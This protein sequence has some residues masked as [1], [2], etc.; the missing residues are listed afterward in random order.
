MALVG[1]A[2][3]F[4]VAVTLLPQQSS[5]QQDSPQESACRTAANAHRIA[6]GEHMEIVVWKNR[7]MSEV[8]RVQADGTISSSNMSLKSVQA[9]GLSGPELL[10][11]LTEKLKDRFTVIDISVNWPRSRIWAR[12]CPGEWGPTE[13]DPC[14]AGNPSFTVSRSYPIRI[15]D[16]LQV[17]GVESPRAVRVG[18]DG[19]MTLPLIG[20]VQAAGLT[21]AELR[22]VV[23]EKLK[24]DDP[25][26]DVDVIVPPGYWGFEPC[27]RIA[28]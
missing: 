3:A 1:L 13:R 14:R 24:N 4:A 28:P 15:G 23:R 16:F 9:A 26:I 17:R 19:K 18:P 10:E 22:R 25:Y 27:I 6:A 7:V 20:D 2:I 21:K 8:I 11:V 5:G 12:R